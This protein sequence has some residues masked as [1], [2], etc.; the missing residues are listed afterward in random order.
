M[1][2]MPWDMAAHFVV[3]E[4][5]VTTAKSVTA[6][7]AENTARVALHIINNGKAIDAFLST[8][9]GV[10][11]DRGLLL[12]KDARQPLR[13]TFDS[14]GPIVQ[15]KLFLLCNGVTVVSFIET[16]L[17]RN[18]CD[19]SAGPGSQVFDPTTGLPDE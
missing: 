7:L 15:R 8:I 1:Q 13:L 5:Q 3:R 19:G 4:L 9:G 10:Y 12:S 6:I 17:V 14:D 2:L 16:C 18:P 11:S